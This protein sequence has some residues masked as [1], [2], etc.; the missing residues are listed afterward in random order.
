MFGS[1]RA[2]AGV[3]GL[4]DGCAG[5]GVLGWVEEEEEEDE[6]VEACA[7]LLRER[8]G[9]AAWS[10]GEQHGGGRE[11]TMVC[12]GVCVCVCALRVCRWGT[13]IAINIKLC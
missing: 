1:G 12:V 13:N 8:W 5:L 11:T 4:E 10:P 7:R 2:G 3:A 6:E 9:R